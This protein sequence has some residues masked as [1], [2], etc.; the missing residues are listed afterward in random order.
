MKTETIKANHFGI[1]F[2]KTRTIT[3]IEVNGSV[4]ERAS[5]WSYT[6]NGQEVR[7]WQINDGK[8]EIFPL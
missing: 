7:I 5:N 8:I 4:G 1:K 2:E 3:T 6:V